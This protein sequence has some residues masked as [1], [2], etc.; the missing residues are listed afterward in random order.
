MPDESAPPLFPD[1][2]Y[3]PSAGTRGPALSQAFTRLRRKILGE[4]TD[5]RLKL[6]ALRATWRTIAG[7]SGA[8]VVAL[9]QLGGWKPAGSVGSTVYDRGRTRQMLRDESAKVIERFR[10]E[11][12]EI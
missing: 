2:P 10:E 9:D 4:E 8:S 3:R 12:Y 11:G 1:V 7:W 6:H 5:G